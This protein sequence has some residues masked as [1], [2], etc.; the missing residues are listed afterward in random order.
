[1]V[2]EVEGMKPYWESGGVS[3]YC[4]DVRQWCEDEYSP[5]SGNR[6]GRGASWDEFVADYLLSSCRLA[7][8]PDYRSTDLGFRCVLADDSSDKK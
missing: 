4:A 2:G 8:S 6:V 1:M 7:Y 3:I 5:G